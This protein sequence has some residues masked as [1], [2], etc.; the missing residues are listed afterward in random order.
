M[1]NWVELFF[2]TL[3][4]LINAMEA[5]LDLDLSVAINGKNKVVKAKLFEED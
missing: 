2:S 3:P 1:K 4:A 5:S